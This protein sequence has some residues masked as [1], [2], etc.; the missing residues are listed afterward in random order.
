MNTVAKGRMT[1]PGRGREQRSW[2]G[3]W[4]LRSEATWISGRI[5]TSVQFPEHYYKI[6]CRVDYRNVNSVNNNNKYIWWSVNLSGLCSISP[7]FPSSS[8]LN[9][10]PFFY[11]LFSS[12]LA[13]QQLLMSCCRNFLKEK[14]GDDISVSGENLIS[15]KQSETAAGRM[16]FFFSSHE[17]SDFTNIFHECVLTDFLFI[18][19]VGSEFERGETKQQQQQHGLVFNLMIELFVSDFTEHLFKKQNPTY[20][21]R[22]FKVKKCNKNL[23]CSWIKWVKFVHSCHC[24]TYFVYGTS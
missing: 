7:H 20:I 5:L 17:T 22:L 1:S 18:K 4:T 8:S 11:L 3:K 21:T 6:R 12:N 13:P 2:L 14:Q 19:T 10:K 16:R 15:N 24:S 23:N 9:S